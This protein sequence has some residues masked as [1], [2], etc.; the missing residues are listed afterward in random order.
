MKEALHRFKFKSRKN[1]AEP[2]GIA[3][4]KYLSQTPALNIQ[5]ID[6]VIPVPLHPWRLRE[7]GY[8]QVHL[9]A[10][11]LNKYYGIPV[12]PALLRT[13]ATA[14]QFDL[15]REKRFENVSGAFKVTDSQAIYNKRLLLL[16]DIYTTGATAAE[17]AKTL[18][19][20]GAKRI[21]IMALSR[22]IC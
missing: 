11:S 13:R 16:D 14:S 9:L 5:E 7:R 21:E 8:N 2:L 10:D 19:I 17:C 6:V 22:A 20:A 1:L 3:L 15:P 4:V 12:V 18:K